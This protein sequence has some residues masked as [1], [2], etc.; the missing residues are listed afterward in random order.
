MYQELSNDDDNDLMSSEED[1][2]DKLDSILYND[3][4]SDNDEQRWNIVRAQRACSW[5]KFGRL[6]FQGP[7]APRKF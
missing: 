5:K 4:K 1:F 7:M 6:E 3:D 2:C